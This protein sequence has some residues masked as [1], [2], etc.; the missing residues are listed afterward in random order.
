MYA[1]WNVAEFPVTGDK[2]LVKSATRGEKWNTVSGVTIAHDEHSFSANGIVGNPAG[3]QEP[4]ES[5]IFFKLRIRAP[6]T[7]FHVFP[8]DAFPRICISLFVCAPA[9]KRK[10]ER[11]HKTFPLVYGRSEVFA[12][13]FFAVE[14]RSRIFFH[15]L[16]ATLNG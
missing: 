16:F 10:K 12:C 2:C 3:W 1:G 6:T 7:N 9:G 14:S 13:N 5:H 15:T 4:T 8:S 11:E